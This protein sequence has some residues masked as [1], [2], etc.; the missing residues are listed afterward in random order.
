[1]ASP[2]D[3]LVAGLHWDHRQALRHRGAALGHSRG[4]PSDGVAG[5]RRG[6]G[7]RRIHSGGC[8]C[9]VGPRRP[10]L[11]RR[12]AIHRQEWAH[13]VRPGQA[14]RPHAAGGSTPA[15]KPQPRGCR[16]AAATRPFAPPPRAPGRACSHGRVSA[17][18][19]AL[20]AGR[21][22]SRSAR[23]RRTGR[24]GAR[25]T[26]RASRSPARQAVGE[27][28]PTVRNRWPC[29]ARHCRAGRADPPRCARPAAR[30]RR[31]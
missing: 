5:T 18:R 10:V 15:R 26:E 27:N 2:G 24:Y 22:R 9:V 30:C 28:T 3:R 12:A 11:H 23:A 7:D 4:L 20:H 21:A 1:M 29:V 19:C 31:R 17:S 8:A 14:P 16:D 13:R 25:A 6:P